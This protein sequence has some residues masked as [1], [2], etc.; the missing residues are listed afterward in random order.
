MKNKLHDKCPCV[1]VLG[2]G[3]DVGKSI[4][5]TALC[6]YFVNQGKA[7][8]PFKA[9]NMSNNSGVT[10]EGLEMGRAQIVQAEAARISPGVD[11][12][13]VLLKPTTEYGSQVIVGGTAVATSC[14][15][16]YYK[17]KDE[18]FERACQSLDTL[19][20]THDLVVIEGAGSCAEVNL[21]EHDFVNFRTAEYADAPVILVADIHRGGVFAQIVGTLAC[22][23]QALQDRVAGFIINRFRGDIS[24]FA[25][26]A[27]WIEKQTGK[28]VFGV[29]PWSDDIV[30][31]QEDSVVLERSTASAAGA[32][33][34]NRIAVIRLPHIS[35]F[36]DFDPLAATGGIS[37][38]FVER[39]A[40]LSDYR[41]VIL[42][43]SKNTLA[44]LAWLKKTGFDRELC[45]YAEN[46]GH[47]LG[48]CGGYQMLGQRILDP[49]GIES[50][51]GEAVGLGLLPAET[52]LRAPKTTTL[53]RF[54]WDAAAGEGYEIHMGE[55]VR[56]GGA[57]LFSVNSRN[58]EA[59]DD[60]DGCVAEQGR[61]M[62]TYI[63]GLFDSA[64]ILEKWLSNI[65]AA[66]CRLPEHVGLAAR[67]REYD[68]LAAHFAAHM[69]MEL[70]EQLMD[71]VIEQG[72]FT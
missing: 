9:Q 43:G 42:P 53:T 50:P 47:V 45:R 28:P 11:M 6:R 58:M 15:A 68:R 26:G 17:K 54:A 14:A 19:R 10:P 8:A 56:S 60:E 48:V 12:N 64:G 32:G 65:G 66:G 20:R 36:T 25:G 44:D 22:L 49:D 16:D 18:L 27:E 52:V 62:G 13:P 55:T 33:G 69:N 4:I 63:H 71:Q 61:V 70:I 7:V 38:C 40:D 46:G 31:E 24:L 30:I 23:P 72:I 57:P 67:N 21:L 39:P 37:L 41:A 34:N 29:L 59:C 35:N 3:S 1:A 2:T 51:H 5:A